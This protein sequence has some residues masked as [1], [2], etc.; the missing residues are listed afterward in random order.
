MDTWFLCGSLLVPVQLRLGLRFSGVRFHHSR[1]ERRARFSPPVR[2]GEHGQ[3]IGDDLDAPAVRW[4]SGVEVQVADQEVQ[5]DL[6][7]CSTFWLPR[8]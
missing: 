4:W 5:G 8:C 1:L 7:L 3:T 2:F 6:L